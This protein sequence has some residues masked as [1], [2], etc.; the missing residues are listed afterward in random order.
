[1]ILALAASV[2]AL[3]T[4]AQWTTTGTMIRPVTLTNNVSIGTTVNGA[5]LYV[6]KST[7]VTLG[8]KSTTAGAT[9]FMDKGSA[10]SNAAFA[11]RLQG[12]TQWNSGM[13]GGNNFSIR[14]VPANTFPLVIQQTTGN[15]GLGTLTP[16]A[17]LDVIGNVKITDGTQAAGKVL[18]SDANGLT[19]WQSISI[20]AET[21]PKVGTL[22]ANKVPKWNG[23]TLQDGAITDNGTSV[24]IDLPQFNY[25]T[26]NN[27]GGGLK[28][29]NPF[30]NNESAILRATNGGPL[31]QATCELQNLVGYVYLQSPQGNAGDTSMLTTSGDMWFRN[32]SGTVNMAIKKTGNVG[33]GTTTPDRPLVVRS[34]DNTLNSQV[35]EL[36]NG[37]GDANFHLVAT[38]GATTNNQ[39]DIMT[40]L[41]LA[42]G[43]N[44]ASVD[45]SFIRFHRGIGGSDGSTSFSSGADVERM[46]ITST[47][48]VGIGTTGPGGQF[49]LSLDQGR[50][51]LTNTWTIVS[52]ARL[53]NIDG[54]YSK[55]LKEIMQL[56][57]IA[58]HYKN[59]GERKFEEQVLN[60]QAVGFT[61][62]DVQKVFPE[63]VGTDADGYLNLNIH[64]I[65]IAQVNAIK[66]LG[67]QNEVKDAKIAELQNENVSMH[68]ELNDMKQCVQ[69]L[70]A[71]NESKTQNSELKTENTLFQN[72]PNPFNQTT[73][74]SYQLLSDA[75]NASIV[76]RGLNGEELKTVTLSSTGKGQVTI[77]AN[78]LAQGTYT[79]TL[80]VNGK[81]VD[82]KLMVVTK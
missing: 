17:K 55:G 64:S 76:I 81:S 37:I 42:Y 22:A 72:Q 57:P 75:K 21:D 2:V 40:R 73:V 3:Q 53:K 45:G 51:P 80:I 19:S 29:N 78:Q 43:D 62:Q 69:S 66:E 14:D 6:E 8:I 46:R 33:I 5:N 28:V 47:G 50:K 13:L 34:A 71:N 20:P 65:I 70:C 16:A 38:K 48:R 31:Y 49:E 41:G 27:Y 67:A 44:G 58:Y 15:V 36:A 59:V 74:I 32:G 26:V 10:A 9:M 35:S 79:Y 56:N 61:A 30:T 25:A 11:Y 23:T 39:G 77:N 82:T 52:D 12:V 54:A 1:M 60:T 63:A 7:A 4:Q 24:T 18:T 68:A